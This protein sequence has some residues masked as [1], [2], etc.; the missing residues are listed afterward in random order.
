M[1]YIYPWGSHNFEGC[2][3]SEDPEQKVIAVVGM[4]GGRYKKVRAMYSL[5]CSVV[6]M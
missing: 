1:T 5:N 3:V 6:R 2:P 4:E